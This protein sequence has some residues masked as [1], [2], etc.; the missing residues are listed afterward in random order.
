MKQINPL[1]V[2]ALLVLLLLFFGYKLGAAKEE[3]LEAKESFKETKEIAIGLSGLRE[4]YDDKQ[5]VEKA[6]ERILQQS[7]LASANIQMQQKS[8]GL[9][10]QSQ[11]IDAVALNSLMSKLLNGSYNIKSMEIQ[12]TSATHASL[13]VEVQW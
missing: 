4:I 11:S 7:S 1:Y 12:K 10:I 13:Y 9:S 2:G 5:R 8:S 3:L 6:I